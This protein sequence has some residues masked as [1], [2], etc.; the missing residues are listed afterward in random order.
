LSQPG[1]SRFAD[2]P[3]ELALRILF[4]ENAIGLDHAGI[5]ASSICAAHCVLTPLLMAVVPVLGLNFIF[6][7]FAEWIFVG[8]SVV[9]GASSLIPACVRRHR[10]FPPLLLFAGG[11]LL[12]LF[13]RLWL[14]EQ[15]H[16]EIPVVIAA[17]TLIIASHL[18]NLRLCRSCSICADDCA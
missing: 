18:T 12:L 14:E 1:D 16:F 15:I 7:G 5:F 17:A 3:K 8:F 9:I 11:S 2:Q 6:G 10:K 13:G 4:R